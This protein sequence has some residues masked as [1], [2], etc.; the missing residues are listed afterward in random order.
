[1]K[2]NNNI[3]NTCMKMNNIYMITKKMIIFGII[4]I[5]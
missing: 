4:Q 3:I 5:E 2:K 1:M